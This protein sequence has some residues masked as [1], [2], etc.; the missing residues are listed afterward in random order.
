MCNSVVHHNYCSQ[1]Q[2]SYIPKSLILPNRPHICLVLLLRYLALTIPLLNNSRC[3]FEP[4]VLLLGIA[5]I[6]TVAPRLASVISVY[7]IDA[8]TYRQLIH[9]CGSK[10]AYSN[11]RKYLL[12]RY[13]SAAVLTAARQFFRSILMLPPITSL[14]CSIMSSTGKCS[15]LSSHSNSSGISGSAVF[16]S[17]HIIR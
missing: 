17:T 10:S 8:H 15:K 12:G 11:S 1:L 2:K 5:H 7:V 6:N 13:I 3:R 9:I 14:S 4:A 16:A